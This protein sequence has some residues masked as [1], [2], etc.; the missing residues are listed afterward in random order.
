MLAAVP[1]CLLMRMLHSIDV[2]PAVELIASFAGVFTV[3]HVP[4]L[5]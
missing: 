2:A 5:G 1:L 4:V 3:G